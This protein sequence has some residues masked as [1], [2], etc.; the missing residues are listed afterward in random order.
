MDYKGFFSSLNDFVKN[1]TAGVAGKTDYLQAVIQRTDPKFLRLFSAQIDTVMS[2]LNASHAK[3]SLALG[4]TGLWY[5]T[6]GRNDPAARYFKQ[7]AEEYPASLSASATFVEFLMY[8]QMWEDLSVEGRKAYETFGDEP[9]FLEMASIGDYN[10][11][12]YDKVLEIC[13]RI[14]E[15]APSD[16]S[17]TLR[18]WYTKGD[19][20]R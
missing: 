8:A 11:G 5:Y 7:N 9:A 13:D 6:T 19:I 10:L 15:V 16:S 20:Y 4:L 1:R 18:A 14:L 3:D 12:R 2:N 17:R